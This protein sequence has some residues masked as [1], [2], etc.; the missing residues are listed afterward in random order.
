MHIKCEIEAVGGVILLSMDQ[1]CKVSLNYTVQ[2]CGGHWTVGTWYGTAEAG[3]TRCPVAAPFPVLSIG[4]DRVE[5]T[6]V[7][8]RTIRR[9]DDGTIA[10]DAPHSVKADAP[11]FI[12]LLGSKS[13]AERGHTEK[14]RGWS[15]EQ[16]DAGI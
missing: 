8:E 14:E 16:A 15:L 6:A 2:M 11:Q 9:E 1:R 4:I 3:T 5:V 10:I 12:E 7:E 13:P